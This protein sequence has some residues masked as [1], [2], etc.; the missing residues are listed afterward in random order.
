LQFLK[1][2]SRKLTKTRW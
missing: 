2:E 1:S